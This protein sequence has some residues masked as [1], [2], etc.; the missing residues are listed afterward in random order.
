[1]KYHLVIEGQ[2][3]VPERE[4]GEFQATKEIIQ[5]GANE[6][7]RWFDNA[8]REALRELENCS[9]VTIRLTEEQ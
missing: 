7:S 3:I 6:T 2:L 8:L 5:R 4:E 9:Q 1:M